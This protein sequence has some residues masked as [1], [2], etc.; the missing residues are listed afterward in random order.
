MTLLFVWKPVKIKGKID[1]YKQQHLNSVLVDKKSGYKVIYKCDNCNKISHTTSHTLYYGKY[2]NIDRQICRSCRSII[3]NHTISYDKFKEI[4]LANKYIILTTKKKFNS[5]L[6]PSQIKVNVIC[7]NGHNHFVSWNN[8][9][10]KG[11]RCR[12]CYDENR[13]NMSFHNKPK[14]SLYKQR[15]KFYTEINYKKF[16]K[17]ERDRYHHLDHKFSQ[18]E[19]FK[20]GILPII[21]GNHINLDIIDSKLNISKYDKCSITK[22]ELFDEYFRQNK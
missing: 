10:G 3:C 16:F 21:I 19:G 4:L 20:Q 8:F 5:Q 2:N 17:E 7:P 1:C 12:L 6:Y 15:V 18:L 22:K 11:R 14:Y 13:Y 9:V